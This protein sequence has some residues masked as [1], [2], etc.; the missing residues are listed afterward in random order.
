[1]HSLILMSSVISKP[2]VRLRFSYQSYMNFCSSRVPASI[3]LAI[4]ILRRTEQNR[5]EQSRAEQNRAEQSRTEQSRTEQNRAEQNRA[6]QSRAEQNRT[7]Q[8]R[9]EQSRT[10]Q[11]RTEQNRAEQNRTE[12]QSRAEQN[13]TEQNRT[14]QVI[15]MRGV[16]FIRVSGG[17]QSGVRIAVRT[18]DFSIPGDIQIVSEAHPTPTQWIMEFLPGGKAVGA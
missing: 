6:E 12:Q 16:V 9:T 15:N 11:N 7:E 5:A 17:T 13:R 18:S 3:L 10:E 4:I 1:M 14:E 8:S 2:S